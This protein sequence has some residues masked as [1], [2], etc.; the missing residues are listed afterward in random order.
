MR[1]QRSSLTPIYQ[2]IKHAIKE[3]IERGDLSPG[4]RVPSE[5]ELARTLGVSRSQTRLALRDLEMEGYLRR[6]QGKPTVVADPAGWGAQEA[7]DSR[8]ARPTRKVVVACPARP[9]SFYP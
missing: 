1:K 6:S 4:D 8:G 3:R 5:N 7:A 2:R 9:R